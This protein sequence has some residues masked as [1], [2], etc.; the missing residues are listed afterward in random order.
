MSL[1]LLIS[2]VAFFCIQHVVYAQKDT[3][4]FKGYPVIA[5]T[6][7][8]FHIKNKLGS[9]SASER[10]ERTSA[11]VEALSEDLL[12]VSDSLITVDDS[13]LVGIVYKGDILLSISKADADSVKMDKEVMA[14]AYQ[15]IIINN[16]NSYRKETNVTE[17]LKRAGLGLLIIIVL[18]VCI[19]FLNK[20]SNKFNSWLS[21]KLHKRI[22]HIKIRDYELIDR[23]R[24]L[25]LISKF[26]NLIKIVVILL[27]VY[28][29]LP[30]IFRLFP[31][32]KP[33]SDS[34]ISFALNP[35]KNI[36]SS[37]IDFFPNLIAIVVIVGVFH[38]VKKAIR[39]LAQ[40]VENERLKINGF[41]PDWAKPTYNIVKILLNAFMLVMIWPYIPGSD[42][43]IFKGVS[44]FLG[45][46]ISFGSSSA[47]SNGV[48]GMV[49]TYMRP[50]RIGDVVKIGDTTGAVLEKS[51]LVTRVKTIKNEII[52]I[53]N[54]AILNGN[55]VNY[56][57]MSINEGLI[58]HSTLTL[59]YDIPWTKIHELLINAAL[60]TE[61]VIKDRTPFVLQTSLDD[62]YVSYQLNAYISDPSIMAII[63][64]EMHKNIHE[65]FDAAGVEIMSPHYQAIRDGNASTLP[66]KL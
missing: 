37:I 9:L 27:L 2:F 16:I 36:F 5:H 59:G 46:L 26:L 38:Y 43:A 42:L 4:I 13:T 30:F 22:G 53:P 21:F 35:L 31:W 55:T 20:Y 12:F 58:I 15:E 61:G 14:K 66:E 60:A 48:A 57:S 40:E 63:Y 51:L 32:T 50:F 7:T 49:I 23:R 24:E 65:A 19:Y 6:D 3:V 62:W 25:I 10:A 56:T 39:F 34:L 1:K 18:G 28:L 64:S 52:T 8:L 54:S 11:K 47:I 41:Y 45:I 33:W 17:L 44:V 29:T